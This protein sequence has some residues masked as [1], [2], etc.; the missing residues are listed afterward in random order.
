LIVLSAAAALFTL[1][2]APAS[3]RQAPSHGSPFF[4]AV[5]YDSGGHETFA[6]DVA[7]V[8]GDSNPDIVAANLYDC[9]YPLCLTGTLGVLLGKG[10]GTFLPAVT[11][12][13]GGVQTVAVIVG[14][15]NRDGNPDIVA[16]N[17]CGSSMAC[18][19]GTV[20][21]LLG[22]GH[23]VFL[24]AATYGSGGYGATSVAIADVDGNGAADVIVA[25]KLGGVGVLAG[26]GDGTFQAAAVYDAGPNYG[27][28]VA[29]ADVSGDG[30]PD[31]VAGN[32][33]DAYPYEC[34][35][36]VGV[37]LGD[38]DG[39][40]QPVVLYDSGEKYESAVE[41][42]DM[43]G[44]RIPDLVTA[45]HSSN[46]VG[47]L[48]GNGDG[49]FQP[50]STYPMTGTYARA[51]AVA[52]VNVDGKPDAVA[53]IGFGETGAGGA[54]AV[55]LGNGDGTL[56]VVTMYDAGGSQ[57][58]YGVKA[59]DVSGDGRPDVVASLCSVTD[60]CGSHVN[61]GIGLLLSRPPCAT[62]PEITMSVS[63]TSIWPPNGQLVPVAVAGT[64][65]ISEPGCAPAAGAY[66]VTDE[67]R[68]VEPSGSVTVGPNGTF[69]FSVL[70][71]A[72][73]LGNDTDGRE[74]T[75]TITATGSGESIGSQRR[76]VIVPHSRGR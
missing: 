38:G 3:G 5:A 12:G 70:L 44:D 20:G 54:V 39:T 14:D 53:G 10:D 75:I 43:N 56:Q 49:T 22:S 59:R 2:Q 66:V 61:G 33:C 62:S 16:A 9:P 46:A 60:G 50:A 40:F 65:T 24:P 37:L 73:R 29:V 13:S 36:L 4:P 7:D 8:N 47:V 57:T 34:I 67:Y 6:V 25:N 21:V 41:I 19:S 42:A 48:L 72:S 30:I 1:A 27:H 32:H 68:R 15:V 18:A 17:N 69:S 71:Q 64:I 35:D 51:I 28:S 58:L 63:P 11:Y 52:D 31:V 55:L 45:N 23:G 26:N 74:Y 76:T